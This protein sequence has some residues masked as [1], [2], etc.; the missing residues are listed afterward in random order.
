MFK[1]KNFISDLRNV[2]MS[3]LPAQEKML[4]AF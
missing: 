4:Y 2:M 3:I 1:I